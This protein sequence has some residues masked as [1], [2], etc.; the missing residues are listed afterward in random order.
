[1]NAATNPMVE[2]YFSELDSKLTDL[3]QAPR[4]DF[5]LELRAHVMDR[6]EQLATVSGDDCR[7]V[8]KALGTP[9]EIARQYRMELLL[10]RPSWKIS[11]ITVLRTAL[12]WTVAGVQGYLVFLVALIG[13]MFAA[14]LYLTALLKPFFPDNVGMY[15]SDKGINLAS[16]PVQH[17]HDIMGNYYVAFAVFMG[18]LFTFG[19]TLLIRLL[20]RRL[21]ALRRSI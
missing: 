2:S 15:V 13:Y 9:E 8:L 18:Y 20:V 7:T 12:R 11:P 14:S 1:M 21:G 16:F 4:R 19:T 6:L 3:P 10:K 17:G 5:L